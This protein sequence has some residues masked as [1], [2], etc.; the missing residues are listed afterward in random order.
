MSAYLINI[1]ENVVGNP[2]APIKTTSEKLSRLFQILVVLDTTSDRPQ[3]VSRQ[4]FYNL[5]MPTRI[6]TGNSVH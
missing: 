1:E 4:P 5:G 2:V 3:W 6:L